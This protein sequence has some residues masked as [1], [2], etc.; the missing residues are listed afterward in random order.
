[1]SENWRRK[2]HGRW[3][4]ST[5]TFTSRDSKAPLIWKESL[6]ITA[7]KWVTSRNLASCQCRGPLRPTATRRN[8]QPHSFLYIYSDNDDDPDTCVST[9]H[10]NICSVQSCH[11]CIV[12]ITV[13]GSALFVQWYVTSRKRRPAVVLGRKTVCCK[14]KSRVIRDLIF[15]R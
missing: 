5:V 1:M 15:G 14:V 7:K 12:C 9:F 13:T 3:S 8:R 4:Q 10:P 6:F 2:K 11:L